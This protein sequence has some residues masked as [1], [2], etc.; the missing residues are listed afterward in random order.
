MEWKVPLE[1]GPFC[2]FIDNLCAI[3]ILLRSYKD[4]TL[5]HNVLLPRSWII[6]SWDDFTTFLRLGNRGV[7]TLWELVKPLEILVKD[8][9][10]GTISP[11]YATGSSR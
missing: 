11:S 2:S 6:E 1:F 3:T 9:Y 5:L 8:I 7:P 10:M 4:S